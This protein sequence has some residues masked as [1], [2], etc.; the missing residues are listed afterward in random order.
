MPTWFTSVYAAVLHVSA[1]AAVT[2]LTATGKVDATTGLALIGS[3]VGFGAGVA[4]T[5]TQTAAQKPT[6]VTVN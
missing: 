4:V 3:L 2:A 6:N 5:P 1:L